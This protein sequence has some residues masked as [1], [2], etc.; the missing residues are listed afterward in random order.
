LAP[1]QTAVDTATNEEGGIVVLG[2]DSAVHHERDA[3]LLEPSLDD[4]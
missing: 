4:F 2:D 1:F 3:D